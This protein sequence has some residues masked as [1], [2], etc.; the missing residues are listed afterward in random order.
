M[1]SF[2]LL[3]AVVYYTESLK[4]TDVRIQQGSC[5]ALKCLRV[6]ITATLTEIQF[7]HRLP[8]PQ[9]QCVCVC[10]CVCVF[11]GDRERGP[12]RRFME[13]SGWGP[14]Q[15]RQRDRPLLWYKHYLLFFPRFLFHYFVVLLYFLSVRLAGKKGYLAFQRMD[16]LYTEM[17]EEAYQNQETEITFL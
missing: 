14:P 5:L 2:L 11:T 8:H 10:V 7:H 6:R 13:V 3:Q 15:R 12:H 1:W 9:R 17:E 4:S 16:Q